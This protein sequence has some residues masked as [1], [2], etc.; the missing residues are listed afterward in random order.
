MKRTRT[1]V[2]AT[3]ACAVLGLGVYAAIAQQSGQVA[4]TQEKD[5]V[6]AL[7]EH[8]M[9]LVKAIEEAERHA[10]GEAISATAQM[11][12]KNATI[13]VACVVGN[14]V[15]HLMVDVSTGKL[16]ESPPVQ[17]SAARSMLPGHAAGYG[18]RSPASKK[19]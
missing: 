5:T 9:T 15:K 13:D 1:W 17:K 7:S 16:T 3:A 10:K 11:S 12:G 6:K 8:H 4:T 18:K 14:N 2:A 19:P